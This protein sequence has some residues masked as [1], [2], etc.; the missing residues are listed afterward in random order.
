M[1]AS[2]FKKRTLEKSKHRIEQLSTDNLLKAKKF[3]D[4][5]LEYKA[6]TKLKST[7]I[8]GVKA[9]LDKTKNGKIYYELKLEG[10]V[11]GRFSNTKYSDLGVSFHTLAR[12]TSIA[13]IR[14][15]F[16][17]PPKYAFITTDFKGMELCCV[18]HIS[19]D[20]LMCRAINE[21]KDLHTFSASMLFDVSEEKV[22]KQQRQI[23]KSVSFLIIYGGQAFNLSNDQNIPIKQAEK[24]IKKYQGLFPRIF[25]YME[26]VHKEI[27][28]FKSCKTIFGRVRHL[29]NASSKDPKVL[30]RCYRQGFNFLVQSP[31]ND[32]TAAALLDTC[33]E[34]SLQNIE[35][36]NVCTVHDSLETICKFDDIERVA[37]IL[38]DKMVNYPLLKAV[39]GLEMKVNLG[40]DME[41][42][43]SFGKAI[44]VKFVN[45]KVANLPEIME[46]FNGL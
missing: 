11:T 3:I 39:F 37:A 2:K 22:T 10:T 23:A 12:E 6:A 44:P 19:G 33:I 46:Q 13:N 34:F 36:R 1:A 42:G 31:A 30:N 25:E 32:M 17:A 5:I 18:A 24:I 35:G 4:T 9:A 40:I 21:G 41:I 16:V 43:L 7:Y 20:E 26:E 29:E 38:Y 28:E 45:G 8:D 27:K 14:E 15:E